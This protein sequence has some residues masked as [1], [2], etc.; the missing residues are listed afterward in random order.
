MW[1]AVHVVHKNGPDRREN[2]GRDFDCER[3]DLLT[4]NDFQVV[5]AGRNEVHR[6]V[7]GWS[8]MDVQRSSRHV[9]ERASEI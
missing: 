2:I 9:D 1:I 6:E 5:N 3:P 7:A 4:V 8:R